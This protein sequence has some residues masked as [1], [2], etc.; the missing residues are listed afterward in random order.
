ME[1]RRKR[2]MAWIAAGLT[3]GCSNGTRPADMSRAGHE[4]AGAEEERL[5]LE[6]E[7]QAKASEQGASAPPAPGTV[8]QMGQDGCVEAQTVCWTSIANPTAEHR[9]QAQQHS[10]LAAR[11]RASSQALSNAERHACSGLSDT[12]RDI[13]P[14]QH[15]EDIVSV[16]RA[17]RVVGHGK[18]AQSHLAGATVVFRALPGMTPQWLQRLV[19]CHLARAAVIGSDPLY[20]P[21]C[22]LMVRGA[23]AVV[24][25]LADGFAVD[26]TADDAAAAQQVFSRADRLRPSAP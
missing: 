11:H 1:R 19:D 10:E 21:Y 25:P 26:V 13:S 12:D 18:V 5:A 6:H 3:V 14:F 9:E 7:E 4:A 17:E 8:V 24:R 16:S 15:T 22:P 23:T 20:M 2:M